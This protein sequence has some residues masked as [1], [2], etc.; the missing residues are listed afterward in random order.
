MTQLHIVWSV[1]EKKELVGSHLKCL[2][3]VE[4]G[5]LKVLQE[6]SR[7]WAESLDSRGVYV[8]VCVSKGSFSRK[9]E[10]KRVSFTRRQESIYSAD[11]FVVNCE[12]W[13]VW[14]CGGNVNVYPWVE[15][16]ERETS[17]IKVIR[18]VGEDPLAQKQ[19]WGY[20]HTHITVRSFNTK[21]KKARFNKPSHYTTQV[22]SNKVLGSGSGF[23]FKALSQ[24][25]AHQG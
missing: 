3:E 22:P 4:A 23:N 5:I 6:S 18:P 10:F 8:Y 12:C 11:E 9:Y 7:V 24:T 15:L 21:K 16:I 2:L 13:C 25:F 20:T 19:I 14:L 1:K 17:L